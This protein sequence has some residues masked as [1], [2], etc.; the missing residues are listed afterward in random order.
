MAYAPTE[1]E[2][3]PVSID[4]PAFKI[5]ALPGQTGNLVEWRDAADVVQAAIG[6]TG[7][8]A[9]TGAVTGATG[10]IST[11]D[12]LTVGG[13]IVPQVIEVPVVIVANAACVDQ[14][15]FVANR[16][17]QVTAIREVHATAGN[18]GSAVNLQVTKDTGTNAPGAGTDLL[19]NNTNAGFDMKGAANTVQVGTLTATAASL[20][21]AAGNRLSL[22]FAG[23]VTTLAGL[24]VTVTLKPI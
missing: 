14:A 16:A 3:T 9:A 13:V 23:T 17:Y 24:C 5:R 20:Q 11:A 19:T 18:D 21:L 8:L 2:L 10:A 12:G 15:F 1:Q 22:D 6:A 7:T 4:K